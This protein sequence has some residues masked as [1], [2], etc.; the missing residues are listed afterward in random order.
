[1]ILVLCACV[2]RARTATRA[3][4]GDGSQVATSSS[5]RTARWGGVSRNSK[6]KRFAND[7]KPMMKTVKVEM[8]KAPKAKAGPSARDK[9]A[10]KALEAELDALDQAQ[11]AEAA[12]LE[13]ERAAL[14]R[15]AAALERAQAKARDAVK[16]KL[17]TA[18]ARLS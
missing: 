18:R 4:I 8:A 3:H 1:M 17:K 14:A 13:A 2:C 9:A 12:A 5:A 15:K 7:S 6:F 11:T 16:A 10:V